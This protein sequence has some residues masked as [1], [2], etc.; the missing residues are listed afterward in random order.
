MAISHTRPVY[1]MF[2]KGVEKWEAKAVFK[3][4]SH[5]KLSNHLHLGA[6]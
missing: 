4:L 3:G 1:V 5:T 2:D 6:Q